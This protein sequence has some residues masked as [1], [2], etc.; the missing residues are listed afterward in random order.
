MRKSKQTRKSRKICGSGNDSDGFSSDT[1][2]H[3]SHLTNSMDTQ[4]CYWY[5]KKRHIA[6]YCPSIA[7]VECV[8]LTETVAAITTLTENYLMTVTNGKSPSKERWYLDCATTIHICGDWRKFEQ[9]TEYTNRDQRHIYNLA[10]SVGG[11]AIRHGAGQLRLRLHGGHRNEVVVRNVLHDKD[12]HNSLSQS[13]LMDW[14]LGIADCPSH[15]LRNHGTSQS[16]SG[17][18]QSWSRKSCS[19]GMPRWRIIRMDEKVARMRYRVRGLKFQA[20]LII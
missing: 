6:Q 3:A 4:E 13:W 19:H 20:W 11:K 12:A 16:T 18:W 2:K 14:G 17:V 9:Y 7:P 8:A 10:A 5:H 15:W 1:E